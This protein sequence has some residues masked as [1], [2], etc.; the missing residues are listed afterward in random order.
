MGILNLILALLNKVTHV[1]DIRLLHLDVF[2]SCLM[3][4]EEQTLIIY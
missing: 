1:F 2:D 3:F 4:L